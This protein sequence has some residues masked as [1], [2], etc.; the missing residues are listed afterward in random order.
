MT[1]QST[2]WLFDLDETLHHAGELIFPIISEQMTRYIMQHLSL[3]SG[4]ASE[5]RVEYWR[6]YG[7]TLTGLQ[8]HH[9]INSSHFLQDTHDLDAL[10]PLIQRNPRLPALFRKL[11]GRKW[12]FSNGP[13]HYVEAIVSHL[14]LRQHVEGVFAFEHLPKAK[15]NA[16]AFMT[17][18]RQAGIAAGSCIMIEDS[19]QNLK[20]AKQLGMRTVW[21]HD[22]PATRSWVDYQI[23]DIAEL[24]RIAG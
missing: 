10:L 15:P 8:R 17:V 16:R 7:A 24:A 6:R 5:L 12:I 2:H 13:R 23:R 19:V 11:P 9:A 1:P 18:L 3:D 4:E 20:T 14:R 22:K 21:L